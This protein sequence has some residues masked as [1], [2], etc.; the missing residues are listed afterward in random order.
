MLTACGQSLTGLTLQTN[1]NSLQSIWVSTAE[2]SG[3]IHAAALVRELS[4]LLPQARFR[5]IG[6][7][8]LAALDCEHL[9]EGQAT[10]FSFEK[11]SNQSSAQSHAVESEKQ[12]ENNLY[13]E[14]A[15][16]LH[17]QCSAR[18]NSYE[19]INCKQSTL[20]ADAGPNPLT[21]GQPL[22]LFTQLFSI[23]QLSVMGG[24]EVLAA[25]PRIFAILR[26]IKKD[27]QRNRPDALILVDA[28]DFNFRLA[29]MA[30][31]FGIPVYYYISPKIWAW[32]SS[33]ANF[34]KKYTRKVFCILPFEPQFYARY[35]LNVAQPGSQPNTPGVAYTVKE[36]A[37]Y[38]GNPLVAA[39]NLPYLDTLPTMP[40]RIGIMPGSRK[41]EI[42]SLLPLFAKASEIMASQVPQLSFHCIQAPGITRQFLEAHWPSSLPLRIEAPQNRYAFMKSCEVILAASGTAT[43]ECALAGTPTVVAYKL[44]P[45]SGFLARLV[46]NVEFVSLP[47]LILGQEV[48]PELLQKN[49]K[50]DLIA[51][52]ARTWLQ[53][54]QARLACK[55]ELK[56]LRVLLGTGNAPQTAALSFLQD[57]A[58]MLSE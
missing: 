31:K 12:L 8:S 30:Y 3:D 15:V 10:A 7:P 21:C 33:R 45:V 29:R 46:L 53:N 28:P 25:L 54:E 35:G 57:Y 56:K 39:M 4:I 58:E 47:N 52:N 13:A 36:Q 48:F 23:Q 37:P 9:H 18:L 50:A 40:G 24:T 41:K 49:A 11:N 16:R 43:L 42:T 32:R 2:P 51:E 34:L 14:A 44:S 1:L 27:W 26:N 55:Q 6:G 17:S 5:G 20:P 19:Q 38:V 22:P